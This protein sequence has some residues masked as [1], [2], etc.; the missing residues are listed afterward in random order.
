MLQYLIPGIQLGTRI[1]IDSDTG[2]VTDIRTNIRLVLPRN[3]CLRCNKLISPFKL[4]DESLGTAERERNRY[5]DDVPAPSVI[6]FNTFAAAQ[7]ANA[8]DRRTSQGKC[9]S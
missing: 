7:A 6:T 9:T 3:G 1:D 2:T 5:I 4:Q 8:H